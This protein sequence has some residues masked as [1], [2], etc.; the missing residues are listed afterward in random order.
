M[1]ANLSVEMTICPNTY[2]ELSKMDIQKASTVLSQRD[3]VLARLIAAVDLPALPPVK[4]PFET[5]VEAVVS[6][7]VSTK[8]A[9]A[10]F[11]RVRRLTANQMKPEAL[12]AA[13]DRALRGAGLSR[14]KVRYIRALAEAFAGDPER[15]QNLHTCDDAE[16]VAALTEITGIGVW[17]AEM[18]L[19]F[20]LL[21]ED[22]FP[23]GDLGI[24]RAVAR[25]I[26]SENENPDKSAMIARAEIWRPYRSVASLCLW[27]AT[28]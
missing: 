15:Y 13:D 19:I 21:R 11:A 1:R 8:A 24:R 9:E 3:P 28:D 25:Y 14:Q 18:F 12:L 17:T 16:V 23:V 6:Q 7:Q 20:H 5:L 10:V 26:F 27:K 2:P 4:G 22:V